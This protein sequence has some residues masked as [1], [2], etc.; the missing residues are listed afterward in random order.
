MLADNG[1]MDTSDNKQDFEAG[2]AGVMRLPVAER[3][4][5]RAFGAAQDEGG[6]GRSAHHESGTPTPI[7][8]LPE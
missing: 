4:S 2:G 1:G 8:A 6:G 7:A 5:T 3:P